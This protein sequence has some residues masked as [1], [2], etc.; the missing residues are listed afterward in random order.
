MDERDERDERDNEATAELGK[1][2]RRERGFSLT[3]IAVVLVIIGLL[4]SGTLAARELLHGARVKSLANDFV[5]V[6][7]A[8]DAYQDRFRALPGDDRQA[9]AHLAGAT[10]LPG[11]ANQRID[12]A[13]DSAQPTDES[14]LFWQHARLAGLL[15][16]RLDPSGDQFLPRNVVSGRVGVSSVSAGQAQVAGLPGSIQVCSGGLPGKLARQL[17]TLL[18][19]GNTAA[20]ALQLVP[21][22]SPSGTSPI[23]TVAVADGLAY[24]ACLV[25]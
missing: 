10:V 11:P 3:E 21:D 6:K 13:W 22:G 20:G 16:G 25:F 18:D 4:A 17:D 7:T 5:S 24:T 23:A 15:P 2:E 19:D 1:V 12:G 8:L 14:T 9:D